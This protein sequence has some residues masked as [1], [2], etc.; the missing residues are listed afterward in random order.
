M[1]AQVIALLPSRQNHSLLGVCLSRIWASLP[2]ASSAARRAAGSSTLTRAQART[3][4][5]TAENKPLK[6]DPLLPQQVGQTHERMSF[7]EPMSTAP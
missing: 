3:V 2:W 4:D 1:G 7:G 5:W 6:V